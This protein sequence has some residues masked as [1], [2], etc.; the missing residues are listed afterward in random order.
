M[1]NLRSYQQPAYV[2]NL[3]KMVSKFSSGSIYEKVLEKRVKNRIGK[4]RYNNIFENVENPFNE[5]EFGQPLASIPE[6]NVTDVL[7]FVAYNEE[8]KNIT[9]EVTGQKIST[10][11]ITKKTIP[12]VHRWTTVYR[13]GILKKLYQLE[14]EYPDCYSDLCM[15]TST[16]SQSGKSPESCL[17]ELNKSR[18]RLI[19]ALRDR[20]GT[21]DYFSILEPHM[22][23][24]PHCHILYMHRLT[25]SEQVEMKY[26]WSSY[27]DPTSKDHFDHGLTFSDVRAS[28]NGE[29]ESGTISKIRG[30]LMKYLVKGLFN[31]KE[32]HYNIRGR[33]VT[34]NMPM[35]ELLFNALLKKHK[36][37]LWTCSRRFSKIMKKPEGDSEDWEC[38]QIDQVYSDE[39]KR[40]YW[41]KEHGLRPSFKHV[42][43]PFSTWTSR[44]LTELYENHGYKIEYDENRSLWVAYENVCV[45]VECL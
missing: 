41:T 12:Y 40:L 14:D 42:W 9:F 20:F 10:G 19:E 32:Y 43:R 2:D 29:F 17:L 38:L 33:N 39:Q 25:E 21:Q 18:R 8:K 7:N 26:T 16:V 22:T 3:L 27:F 45:P 30:Y 24:Y 36:V 35:N 37:K 15:I 5:I 44:P 4:N 23:G 6:E 28:E 31:Q 34:F 13:K 11:E 1:S